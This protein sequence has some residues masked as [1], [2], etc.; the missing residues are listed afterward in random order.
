[1]LARFQVQCRC[2]GD[3]QDEFSEGGSLDFD[4]ES[5]RVS[6]MDVPRFVTG[7]ALATDMALA[8]DNLTWEWAIAECTLPEPESLSRMRVVSLPSF[9][10]WEQQERTAAGD[11][12]VDRTLRQLRARHVAR[13]RAHPQVERQQRER[14]HGRGRGEGVRKP[15]KRVAKSSDSG[16]SDEE[17]FLCHV[18]RGLA[19]TDSSYFLAALLE[20]SSDTLWAGLVFLESEFKVESSVV[21]IGASGGR[22]RNRD[23]SLLALGTPDTSRRWRARTT[24]RR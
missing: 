14:G 13:R 4:I 17:P 7:A 18:P 22:L 21:R 23:P 8:G 15:R 9:R 24:R 5:V 11:E 10:Q 1:M 3:P 6:D 19:P 2:I 20:Q 16:S 12:A